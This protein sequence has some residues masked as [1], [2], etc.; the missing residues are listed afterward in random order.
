MLIASLGLAA[1]GGSGEESAGLSRKDI[2]AKANAI[3]KQAAHD[4]QTI[5]MPETLEGITPYIVEMAPFERRKTRKLAA[6][7]PGGEVK[8]DWNA[9]LAK[10]KAGA[11]WL[12]RVRE[13]ANAHGGVMTDRLYDRLGAV[14]GDI[15]KETKR[16]G[17]PA[18]DSSKSSAESGP[19]SS[20]ASSSTSSA[21]NISASSATNSPGLPR[22]E[23]AAK[24][25]AICAKA[26][27]DKVKINEAE[28]ARLKAI[29]R[30]GGQQISDEP[31]IT[32]RL[33]AQS[34]VAYA[35]VEQRKTQ[36]LAALKPDGE[37]EADWNAFL[38]KQK[39]DNA[40]VQKI[41]KTAHTQGLSK[42]EDVMV[43]EATVGHYSE[44]KRLGM[45]LCL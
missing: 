4:S 12:Q 16:L 40:Y 5:S 36:K 3:C 23:I 6:L 29:E 44:M 41:R 22:A 15:S 34:L 38:V 37:V 8:A 14:P 35:P 10:Q 24:A 43:M 18:C 39:R 42:A 21:T 13:T 33:I 17:I 28:A 27:Q 26:A 2:A 25:D 30:A 11:A 20:T 32:N 1:C 9:F 31:V 45:T 19:A 7:K